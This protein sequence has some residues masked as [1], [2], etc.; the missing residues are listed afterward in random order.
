MSDFTIY[1]NPRCSKSRTT[2]ALL[3]ANGI[4]PRVVLYL[5]TPPSAG[6]IRALLGKLGAAAD[7]TALRPFEPRSYADRIAGHPVAELGTRPILYMRA[8][9][10]EGRLPEALV[11]E[12]VA[13][14]SGSPL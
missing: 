5:E 1:H 2:L 3:E 4:Q 13:G 9:G 14:R 11:A 12:V 10:R 8:L 7:S 6:Q